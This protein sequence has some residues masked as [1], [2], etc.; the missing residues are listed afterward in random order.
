MWQFDFTAVMKAVL[1]VIVHTVDDVLHELGT[2]CENFC[3]ALIHAARYMSAAVKL[4][5]EL[6]PTSMHA[7]YITHLQHNCAYISLC[8]L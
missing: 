7:T 8:F 6:Y 2:S 4:L 1:N 3:I 5:K